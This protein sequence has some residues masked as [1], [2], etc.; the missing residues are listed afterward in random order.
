MAEASLLPA[1][2]RSGVRL[3]VSPRYRSGNVRHRG[4]VTP[5]IRQF[6]RGRAVPAVLSVLSSWCSSGARTKS[7]LPELRFRHPTCL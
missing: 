1:T 4:I 3:I 2:T 6:W 7:A 5:N